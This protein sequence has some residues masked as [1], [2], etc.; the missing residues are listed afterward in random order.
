[1]LSLKANLSLLAYYILV[2]GHVNELKVA[3]CQIN[4]FLQK[5]FINKAT[6][7]A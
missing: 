2:T 3:A 5:L 7:W 1:M 4:N 6:V